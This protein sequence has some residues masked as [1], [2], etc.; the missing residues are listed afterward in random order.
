MININGERWRIR[1]VSPSHPILVYKTGLPAIGCCDDITKTIYISQALPYWELK[2]VLCHE[3]VHAV[4]YSF[5]IEMPDETEEIVANAIAVF[6][7]DIIILT[8]SLLDKLI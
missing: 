3:L 1:L 6:G 7:E 2:E 5:N 4:M 8:N